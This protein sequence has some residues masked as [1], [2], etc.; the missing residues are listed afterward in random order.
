MSTLTL[1]AT[2]IEKAAFKIRT[3]L[4]LKRERGERFVVTE[5]GPLYAMELSGDV[6]LNHEALRY[7]RDTGRLPWYR[8]IEEQRLLLASLS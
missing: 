4:E 2:A 3:R 8:Y 5:T 7:L 1:S 6:A